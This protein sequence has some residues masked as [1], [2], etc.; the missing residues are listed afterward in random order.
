MSSLS[1]CNFTKTAGK[2]S[3][4]PSWKKCGKR[5]H[6]TPW[7]IDDMRLLDNVLTKL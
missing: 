5:G 2:A 1:T 3:V 7:S 6:F 4:R